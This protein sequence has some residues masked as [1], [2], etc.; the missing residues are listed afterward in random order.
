[1]PLLKPIDQGSVLDF[2]SVRLRALQDS[3]FAFGSTFEKESKLSDADWQ[4]RAAE[5]DGTRSITYLAWD[6]GEACGIA[7][8]FIDA[9]NDNSAHLVSVWVAPTHRTRGIGKLLVLG[10]IDWARIRGV[11]RLHL[12]VTS[13]NDAAIGFYQQLGFQKTGRTEPYPNDSTVVEFEIAA[14][15]M[16]S[17]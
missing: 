11:A 3:P 8:G 5:R 14:T 6:Q 2:K 15:I 13:N 1:M 16:Q 17:L 7:A 10:V 4:R 9:E 12:M